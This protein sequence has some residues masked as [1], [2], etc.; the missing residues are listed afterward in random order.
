MNAQSINNKLPELQ[1]IITDKAPKI[2]GLTETWLHEDINEGEISLM[3]FQIYRSDRQQGN[4]GGV[5]MYV[6]DSL[7]SSPC[8]ELTDSGFEESVWCTVQLNRTSKLLV[9][10]IYRSPASSNENNLKLLTL[11]QKAKEARNIT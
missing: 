6:H 11:L 3:N 10:N 5:L 2:V 9:G 8:Q 4:G 7:V 1:Q